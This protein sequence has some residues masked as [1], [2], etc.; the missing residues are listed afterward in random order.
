MHTSQGTFGTWSSEPSQK[1]RQNE[2]DVEKSGPFRENLGQRGENVLL[3]GQAG[4]RSC[5]TTFFS[6]SS[7]NCMPMPLS[8]SLLHNSAALHSTQCVWTITIRKLCWECSFFGPLGS[9][10]NWLQVRTQ[11]WVCWFLIWVSLWCCVLLVGKI[12][13]SDVHG[14]AGSY[15]NF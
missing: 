11:F 12:G 6:S 3:S 5:T 2:G 13:V 8:S 14:T 4:Q 9:F 7:I 1:R 15:I 10:R